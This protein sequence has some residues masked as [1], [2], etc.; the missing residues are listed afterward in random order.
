MVV[1]LR[2]L[3]QKD[4]DAV[5]RLAGEPRFDYY[6]W[7]LYARV[8]QWYEEDDARLAHRREALHDLEHGTDPR[9]GDGPRGDRKHRAVPPPDDGPARGSSTT[10]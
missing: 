7:D 9:R 8:T 6:C 10:C 5:R 4:L 3:E 2:E 1:G